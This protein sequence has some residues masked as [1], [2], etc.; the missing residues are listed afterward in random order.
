MEALRKAL[1]SL[2][3]DERR[4]QPTPGIPPHRLRRLAHGAR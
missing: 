2:T 4:F 3:A 1:D